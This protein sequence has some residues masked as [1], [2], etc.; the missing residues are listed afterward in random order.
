MVANSVL[1]VYHYH[2][3]K[4]CVNI[5]MME[6]SCYSEEDVEDYYYI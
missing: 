3:D 4:A 2:L 1:P 6:G 5:Q